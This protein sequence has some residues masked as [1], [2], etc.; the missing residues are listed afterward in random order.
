M[1]DEKEDNWKKFRMLATN[2]VAASVFFSVFSFSQFKLTHL[3]KH[4]VWEQ[5]DENDNF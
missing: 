5:T 1:E 4:I 2:F 3:Q